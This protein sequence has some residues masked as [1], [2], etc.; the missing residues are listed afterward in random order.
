MGEPDDEDKKNASILRGIETEDVDL[1]LAVKLL[2][3]PRDLG[4][5]E[6]LKEPILAQDG[7]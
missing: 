4:V 6:E 3:L 2:S 5:Y 1:E 7:R